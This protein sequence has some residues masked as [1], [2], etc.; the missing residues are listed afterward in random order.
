[1][2]HIPILRAG[3]QYKSLT[4]ITIP[5]FRTG[6]P[7]AELSQANPGLIAK[8]MRNAAH[9]K[10]ALE[11][12]PI[13]ELLDICKEA[14]RYFN[15]AELP[16]GDGF[17]SPDDY[18]TNLS[19]TTGMPEA[20]CRTNMAKITLVMEEMEAVLGGLTRGLDLNILDSGWVEQDGRPLNFLCETNA[21]GAILPSNSPGV[22]SLWIQAIALKVP[23]VLKPGT[24]E[25]WSPYR[26]AQA[27]MKAGCP[28]EVFGFY[29]TSH[30]GAKEILLRTGRSM[31]FGDKNTV[32]PWKNDKRVQIHGPGWSK[33]IF[34][35]DQ[36]D[37]Y[38]E[39]LDVVEHSVVAN[40]GRSC[41]NASGLWVPRRGREI[42]EELA[43]RLA[44]VEAC[45]MDDKNAQ[46]A[47]FANKRLAYML[48]DVIDQQI[49]AGGAE[50]LTAK[51]RDGGRLVEMND[52]VFLLPTVVY[53]EDPHHPLASS[54][55]LF[56]FV[57]V[58]ESPQDQLLNDMGPTLVVTA[59]TEDQN[60][61]NELFAS[62]NVERLNIGPVPT[63]KIA[64]DQPHEGNLF[65]H[66]YRQRALHVQAALA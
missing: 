36:V 49:A 29:P 63:M 59:I 9:N 6:E 33:V 53:C 8:D 54:E 43:K 12:V 24:Q 32:A 34:G 15:E 20:L 60:Y 4:K 37:D 66:L 38:A 61:V 45:S 10:K 55:Y 30:D 64:W 27:F 13:R 62:P 42:A 23:V 26:I 44:K 52:C 48:N 17:Q 19:A 1:M 28:P 65:E 51:Y 40:G 2:I 21:L 50:D 31:F 58:V 41:I 7:V 46:I 35:E 18:I 22:H 39:Y 16:M 3:K 57:T 47:A 14:A 56:P 25:P 5:H 11:A